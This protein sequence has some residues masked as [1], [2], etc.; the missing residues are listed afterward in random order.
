[1][2]GA[3]GL[4][5]GE[6]SRLLAA[7]GDEVIA[8]VR[9][10]TQAAAVPDA[11]VVVAD[12]EDQAT[13]DRALT[14]CDALVHVAGIHLGNAVARLREVTRVSSVVVVSTA[15]IDS[16]HRDAATAYRAGEGAIRGVRPDAVF[17]RPT[18]VYGSERDRNVHRVIEFAA[19]YRFLPLLADGKALL[20]PIHYADLAAV[21]V[22]LVGVDAAAPVYAGGADAVTLRRAGELIFEALELRPRFLRL[23]L[24]P[25]LILA[26]SVDRLFGSRWR[27]R[28]ARTREDRSTDITQLVRLTGMRPRE[29]AQGIHDEV[30]RLRRVGLVA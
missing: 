1:M 19:R 21:V 9:R 18:M 7:R 20:Q 24:T 17:V 25:T 11:R 12:C 4:T 10:Q 22:A 23:P 26:G 14:G 28:L 27:E 2:T 13:M 29:F 5:G 6:V 8:V 30:Q 3:A 15:G 16:A